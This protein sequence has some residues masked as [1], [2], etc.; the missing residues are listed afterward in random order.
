MLTLLAS[1]IYTGTTTISAGTLAGRQRQQRRVSRQPSVSLSNNAALFS[2]DADALTY[3]GVISGS[4]SLA[5]IGQGTPDLAGH[6]H[7]HGR[8][9]DFGRHAPGGQWQC[10]AAPWARVRVTD[11]GTLVFNLAGARDRWP[12]RSAAAAA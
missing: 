6:Q 7:L 10:R 11:T 12:A 1:N 3:A 4:G 5:Q 2:I 8:H 9:D